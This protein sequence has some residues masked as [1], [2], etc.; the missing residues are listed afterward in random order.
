MIMDGLDQRR[1]LN[2]VVG[3]CMQ[4]FRYKHFKEIDTLHLALHIFGPH[5]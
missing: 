4:V 1:D 2:E 3:F 5:Q